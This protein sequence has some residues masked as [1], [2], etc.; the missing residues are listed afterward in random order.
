MTPS[1]TS[2]LPEILKTH[3]QSILAQWMKVQAESLA[4]RRDLMSDAELQRQSREF[5]AAVVRTAETS[6]IDDLQGSSWRPVRDVLD[7]ISKSRAEQGFTPSA[8]ELIS[9]G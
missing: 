3:E 7:R 2:R 1:S 8:E 9:S 5:L 4:T 6:G